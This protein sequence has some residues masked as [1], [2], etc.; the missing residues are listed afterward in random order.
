[1]AATMADYL[2]KLVPG[3]DKLF[4]EGATLLRELE[5]VGWSDGWLAAVFGEGDNPGILTALPSM[6]IVNA[7]PALAGLRGIRPDL[8]VYRQDANGV[9]ILPADIMTILTDA[10]D[11]HGSPPGLVSV[12]GLGLLE[13]AGSSAGAGTRSF[14]LGRRAGELLRTART[15]YMGLEGFMPEAKVFDPDYREIIFLPQESGGFNTWFSN[16]FMNTFH[17]PITYEPL[18]GNPASRGPILTW[19]VMTEGMFNSLAAANEFVGE[20]VLAA[21]T[22]Q[23]LL[24][25]PLRRGVADGMAG[26]DMRPLLD[27]SPMSR[28]TWNAFWGPFEKSR[29]NARIRQPAN[30]TGQGMSSSVG[31]IAV[32]DMLG[33]RAVRSAESRIFSSTPPEGFQGRERST[34]GA[35]RAAAPPAATWDRLFNNENMRSLWEDAGTIS[36]ESVR[37]SLMTYATAPCTHMKH[38]K[39]FFQRNIYVPFNT[40]LVRPSVMQEASSP[41]VLKPGY[42]TG[43]T[44]I[45]QSNLMPGGDAAHQRAEWT[46]SFWAMV[47]VVSP[48]RVVILPNRIPVRYISGGGIQLF[49]NPSQLKL[50]RLQR[51][52]LIAFVVPVTYKPNL[53]EPMGDIDFDGIFGRKN[54]PRHPDAILN[55]ARW[56]LMRRAKGTRPQS[57]GWHTSKAVFP[58]YTWRGASLDYKGGNYVPA[59]GHRSEA[60]HPGSRQTWN[61]LK[62]TFSTYGQMVQIAS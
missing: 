49:E 56:R 10:I 45:T 12:S 38:F 36:D 57:N 2:H 52:D 17:V 26:S 55:E 15:V 29:A 25:N 4:V 6:D 59:A 51:P 35:S 24:M 18:V 27:G 44:V 58:D 53:Y 32:D 48:Q 31:G 7:A 20:D 34:F 42:E 54:T 43:V 28:T 62:P 16:V 37:V 11:T 14:N 23:S 40:K 61:G 39:P 3:I 41:I 21:A 19:M 1:V 5:T 9:P 50:G 8:Q 47:A 22:P 30:I 60:S 33:M 46:F 13:K